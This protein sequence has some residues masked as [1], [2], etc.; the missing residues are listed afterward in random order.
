MSNNMFV[1]K[2]KKILITK[3]FIP[4]SRRGTL[5]SSTIRTIENNDKKIMCLK[6]VMISKQK[7]YKSVGIFHDN[8]PVQKEMQ[9]THA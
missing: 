8:V 7:C 4:N 2:K 6:L 1:P 3:L 5:I 9:S